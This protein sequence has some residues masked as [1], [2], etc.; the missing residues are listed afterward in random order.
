MKQCIFLKRIFEIPYSLQKEFVSRPT[1]NYYKYNLDISSMNNRQGLQK[2]YPVVT[3]VTC[4]LDSFFKS[5][6]FKI[7]AKNSRKIFNLPKRWLKI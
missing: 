7:C 4:S 3:F 1:F 5:I 2:R 6:V